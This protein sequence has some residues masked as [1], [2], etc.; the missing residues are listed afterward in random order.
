MQQRQTE[1]LVE[2]SK[3][4]YTGLE[5]YIINKTR[6]VI[7]YGSVCNSIV[8]GLKFSCHGN[9]IHDLQ[10]SFLSADT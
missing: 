6:P 8:I 2:G 1:I 4:T 3:C 9:M 10:Y 7:E 5:M